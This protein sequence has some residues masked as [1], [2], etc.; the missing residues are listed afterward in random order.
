MSQRDLWNQRYSQKGSVWGAAP[1]Q[2]VAD[3]LVDLEP[4]RILDLGCGQGRNAIWLAGRGHEVTAIDVSDLAIAQAEELAEAAGVDIEFV[5]ADV[6]AWEPARADFDLVLLSYF[7]A[8]EPTRRALHR[9]AA[10]ALVPGGKVFIIAHHKANL[11]HGIGGP[12]SLDVLFDEEELAGDFVGFAI[13]ENTKVLRHV[14]R[15][16]IVGDAIDLLFLARKA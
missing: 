5:V 15:G 4:C 11:E 13:E 6:A 12:P 7:Q 14:D 16:D 10:D 8:T 9:K 2:F 1:N 3:R